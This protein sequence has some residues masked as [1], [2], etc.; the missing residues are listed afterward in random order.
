MC[1][2]R[3]SVVDKWLWI[4]VE[5]ESQ[6]AA[7]NLGMMVISVC[8][9]AVVTWVR[10]FVKVHLYSLNG[11]NLLYV[12]YTSNLILKNSV[13]RSSRHGSVVNESN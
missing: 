3:R 13:P 8:I 10:T 7:G 1:S 4:S 11:C 2:D 12:N 5:I 9:V 6:K